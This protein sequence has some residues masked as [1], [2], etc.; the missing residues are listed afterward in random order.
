MHNGRLTAPSTALLLTNV[1]SEK[2]A[3]PAKR[4]SDP[5]FWSKYATIMVK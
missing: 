3:E 4:A 1:Q 2:D 5:P